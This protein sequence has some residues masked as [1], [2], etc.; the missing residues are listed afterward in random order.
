MG[1]TRLVG[2]A[3]RVRRPVRATS[4]P[5]RPS[6]TP[7]ICGRRA[8][9]L[10]RADVKGNK[11]KLTGLV[12]AALYGKKVTIQTDPKGARNSKFTKTGTVTASKTTG[13]FT[14][15]VPRPKAWRLR[16]DPLP[17]GL[18]VGQVAGL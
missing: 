6:A 7:T 18:R 8:I 3:G 13:S 14:A 11:V 10:V 4:S 5:V 9:S 1:V 15:T 16:V 2:P 17:G 12:G